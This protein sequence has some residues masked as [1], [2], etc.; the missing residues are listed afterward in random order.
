MMEKLTV[1]P[2]K[3]MW[4]NPKQTIRAVV[5]HDPRYRFITLCVINGLPAMLQV[6][7]NMSL[8]FSYSLVGILLGSIFLSLFAGMIGITVASGLLYLTGKWIGGMSSF[9]QIRCAVSWSN[10]TNVISILMWA[11]LIVM[12][13]KVLFTDLF[14]TASFTKKESLLLMGVFLTQTVMSVWSLVLLVQSLAEV[15]GF[16]SWKSILNILLS[17]GILIAFFWLIGLFFVNG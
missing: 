15:Q 17:F 3:G 13:D 1:N 10:V 7:Q 16:S 12:F 6:A 5:T 9:L 2:W 14:E 4:T 11:I 8:G